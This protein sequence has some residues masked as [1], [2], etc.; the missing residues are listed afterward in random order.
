[1]SKNLEI[2]ID[3]SQEFL[4]KAICNLP[5]SPKGRIISLSNHAIEKDS[6]LTL[7]FNKSSKDVM[8][9]IPRKKTEILNKNLILLLIF[10]G[11]LL[12]L[13]VLSSYFITFNILGESLEYSRTVTLFSLISLEIVSAFNFRS[14]RKG[15][16]NRGLFVNPYLFYA[17]VI[18]LIATFSI[19]YSPLNKVF[20]TVPL[21]LEGFI[22]PIFVSLVLI[23][24]F[25]LL[26]YINNKKKFF[27]LEHI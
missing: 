11:S 5:A 1:M 10:T 14:F 15:I 7:G 17:S 18:S 16:L 6:S 2:V 13:L 9:D 26:K 24:I 12:A 21:K 22:I 23:I 19:I 20:E 4:L 25:D 3:P 27:D 8:N